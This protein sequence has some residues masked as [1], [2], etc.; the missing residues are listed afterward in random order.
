ME[1]T[2]GP[3]V[4]HQPKSEESYRK[5]SCSEAGLGLRVCTCA[6]GGVPSF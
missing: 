2:A 5:E 1:D 4:G 6:A 3:V